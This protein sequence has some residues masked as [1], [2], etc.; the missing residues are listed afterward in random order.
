MNIKKCK[1]NEY[2]NVCLWTENL[3]DT[4]VLTTIN[5]KYKK[6]VS[7][8]KAT[9]QPAVRKIFSQISRKLINSHKKKLTE[10]NQSIDM[11][12]KK[13]N[14]HIH[15]MKKKLTPDATNLRKSVLK[16]VDY[17]TNRKR[18]TEFLNYNFYSTDDSKVGQETTRFRLE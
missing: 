10:S 11:S 6:R 15:G 2:K 4:E 14:C 5:K 7:N 13:P 18:P 17:S 16:R 12:D 8:D 9:Y 1:Q 3:I